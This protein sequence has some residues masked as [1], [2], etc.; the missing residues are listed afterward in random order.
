MWEG[1]GLNR[2]RRS[3]F[4]GTMRNEG[5]GNI[6][7]SHRRFLIPRFG[8][9]H[10]EL[11]KRSGLGPRA[12]R[13][14]SNA[15][16]SDAERGTRNVAPLSV[17]T[18]APGRRQAARHAKQGM[19]FCLPRASF[20]P[21][22]VV[23]DPN[24]VGLLRSSCPNTPRRTTASRPSALVHARVPPRSSPLVALVARGDDAFHLPGLRGET[25]NEDARTREKTRS[26]V[27]RPSL[28]GRPRKPVESHPSPRRLR[29]PRHEPVELRRAS[30]SLTSPLSRWRDE[31][32][33]L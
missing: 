27:L 22:L 12:R 25:R 30:A 24:F 33:G 7:G 11:G 29:R 14:M 5:R 23:P 21:S 18:W 1:R 31:A 28:F 17:R 32:C 20:L 16:G 8:S 19:A 3:S 10:Q 2:V 4:L 6:S 26:L 15:E 9:D 13:G